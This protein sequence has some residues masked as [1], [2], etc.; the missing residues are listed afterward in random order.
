MTP[1]HRKRRFPS[2]EESISF[3]NLITRL[4]R[5]ERLTRDETG[6]N[7]TDTTHSLMVALV[8]VELAKR[9]F[10]YTEGMQDI[11]VQQSYA[12]IFLLALTHDLP[13][14]YAGDTPYINSLPE[15]E[16]RA[17][18]EREKAAIQRIAGEHK[19]FTHTI[20]GMRAYEEEGKKGK[21]T[22]YFEYQIVHVV[23][24]V[25]PKVLQFGSEFA[26]LIER[27]MHPDTLEQGLVQQL[28]RLKEEAPYVPVTLEW[29]Q[30]V[31]EH[32]IVSYRKYLDE[33]NLVFTV[34]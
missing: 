23:D 24:K 22:A 33:H 1:Y 21:G 4:G 17:K 11:N 20:L 5:V 30:Q 31:F 16:R 3:A 32:L 8:A 9:E 28:A 7:E 26:V 15:E 25:L 18:A 27:Q 10:L 14:A 29:A 19:A 13:E 34:L 2:P 6:Q 12:D